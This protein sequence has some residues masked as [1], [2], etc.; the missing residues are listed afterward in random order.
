MAKKDHTK[1]EQNHGGKPPNLLLFV[2]GHL[3]LVMASPG[4]QQAFAAPPF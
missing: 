4:I 3:E 2:S 1:Q